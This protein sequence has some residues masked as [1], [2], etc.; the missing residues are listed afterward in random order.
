MSSQ[1]SDQDFQRLQETLLELKTRNYT[2][3]DQA[4]KQRSALGDATARVTVLQQELTKAKKA[5]DKSKKITEVQSILNDN[6]NLQRKLLSQEDDFRL[7]NQTL[8]NELTILVTENEKLEKDLG[9]KNS[10]DEKTKNIDQT[11][12][13]NQIESLTEKVKLYENEETKSARKI[14]I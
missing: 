12:L 10:S 1:L 14:L 6:E 3:E 7:Q 13:T 4:R 11:N 8:L 2:L 9:Q 5:I